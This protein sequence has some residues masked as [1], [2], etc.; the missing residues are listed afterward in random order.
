MSQDV[1]ILRCR[2]AQVPLYLRLSKFKLYFNLSLVLLT[3]M[4][5]VRSEKTP[6]GHMRNLFSQNKS[7]IV[8][9]YIYVLFH[10]L[11]ICYLLPDVECLHGTMVDHLI[12]PIITESVTIVTDET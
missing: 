6:S 10:I 9:I 8:Y 4:T 12:L 11:L 5:C 3:D 7:R 1:G 2:I